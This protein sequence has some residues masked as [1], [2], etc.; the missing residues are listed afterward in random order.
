MKKWPILLIT[1]PLAIL[2]VLCGYMGRDDG[3]KS[4]LYA[5][6]LSDQS[7]EEISCWQDSDG[8]FYIF[9]PSYAELSNTR[10]RLHTMV[11]IQIDGQLITDNLNG[12]VFQLGE[13][14]EL[15]YTAWGKQQ[16]ST[17]TFMK[18]ANIASMYIDTKSGTMD[19][20]HEEKG[21]KEAG[22]I[23]IY[24]AEGN[25]SYAGELAFIKGRGNFTWS[26][27]EKKPYSLKLEESALLLG[28]GAAEKWILL[29]NAGGSS[30]IRNKIV[31]S[32]AQ[33]F[34][35]AYTAGL[36]LG[37]PVSQWGICRLVPIERAQRSPFRAGGHWA[38]KLLP[39]VS[40]TGKQAGSAELSLCVDPGKSG[41]AG[42]LSGKPNEDRTDTH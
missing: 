22:S 3:E 30:Y 23:R 37:G 42:A 6:I 13:Q 26:E 38:G 40:G 20:I 14:Y 16:Y 31:Y 27:Y 8:Q 32:F 24:D 29:A 25:K 4:L 9:L 11:P 21:N 36:P 35:M 41:T 28:M 34:G 33:E 39:C 1:I 10:L 15:T 18:S 12:G 5:T 17:L 2:V 19:Y 7:E